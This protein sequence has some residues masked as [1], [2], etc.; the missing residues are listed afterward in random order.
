MPR[1]LVI[2]AA[3]MLSLL[4]TSDV[5]AVYNADLGRWISRDPMRYVDGTSLYGYARSNPQNASDP[6]GLS[7]SGT[8]SCQTRPENSPPASIPPETEPSRPA[9]QPGQPQEM[10]CPWIACLNS[11]NS[12]QSCVR[13]WIYMQ[14]YAH[15]CPFEITCWDCS[16]HGWELPGHINICA[17]DLSCDDFDTVL[18]HE[19]VHLYDDCILLDDGSCQQKLC[20]E[21]RAYSYSDCHDPNP[22]LRLKCALKRAKDSLQKGQR[23]CYNEL[24]A[25]CHGWFETDPESYG[26]WRKKALACMT[27][28]SIP[29]TLPP[30]NPQ[31]GNPPAG[32][33]GFQ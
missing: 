26:C 29:C 24:V 1:Q 31:G 4:V 11:N 13:G 15:Q 2:V 14:L 22:G 28:Y 9:S 32:D 25:E 8:T 30:P 3:I 18:T 21:V 5:L 17:R 7:C 23:A 19:L 20:T 27:P 6:S 33:P 10:D 16:G 12:Y